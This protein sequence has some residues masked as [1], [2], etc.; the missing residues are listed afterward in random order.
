M[1]VAT[2][3]NFAMFIILVD[4]ASFDA[5]LGLLLGDLA[6]D[7]VSESPGSSCPTGRRCEPDARA[8]SRA[9]NR[10]RDPRGARSLA[11]R[12]SLLCSFGRDVR[13]ATGRCGK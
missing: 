2:L 3:A 1:L 7:A 8:V 4:G 10:T 9:S 12:Y 5:G 11:V 13:F 6:L